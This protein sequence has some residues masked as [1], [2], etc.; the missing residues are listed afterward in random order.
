MSEDNAT[1]VDFLAPSPF[2]FHCVQDA[3]GKLLG[4][5]ARG[6]SIKKDRVTGPLQPRSDTCQLLV[7]Y[8]SSSTSLWY[9]LTW[10]RLSERDKYHDNMAEM[11]E[12]R[13]QQYETLSQKNNIATCH[14]CQPPAA[15]PRFI[16]LRRFSPALIYS[17]IF[18]QPT[19]RY[20]YV[21]LTVV[22]VL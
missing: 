12:R 4:A 7:T 13:V 22:V 5:V 8:F 19:V 6:S 11:S 18:T 21:R 3:P 15:R 16:I 2:V 20:V 10:L 1:T 9:L 14:E 17:A